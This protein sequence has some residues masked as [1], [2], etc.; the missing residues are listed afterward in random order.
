[1]KNT[2][3]MQLQ[4]LMIASPASGRPVECS[5]KD[6]QEANFTSLHSDGCGR[7]AGRQRRKYPPYQPTHPGI[8]TTEY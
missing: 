7:Q 5:D 2:K 8:G 1:M 3:I 4:E 6:R